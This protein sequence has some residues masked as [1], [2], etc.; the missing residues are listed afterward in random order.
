[1]TTAE[2]WR[3]GERLLVRFD[4]S[5]TFIEGL[6]R[7]VPAR[8]RR[9]HPAERLWSVDPAMYRTVRDLAEDHFD[10]VEIDPALEPPSAAASSPYDEL[11][12]GLPPRV[13]KRVYRL[14][15]REVHPDRAGAGSTAL[16]QRVNAAWAAIERDIGRRA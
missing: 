5:P 7:A 9:Y 6:K 1:M 8:A 16:A 11:L 4:Y 3:E 12:A 2:L 15:V 13:L 10:A 14:I